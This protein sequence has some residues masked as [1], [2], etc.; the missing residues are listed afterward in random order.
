VGLPSIHDADS[1]GYAAANL[2]RFST[3]WFDAETG[4]GYWGYRYYT[5]EL[6]RW[7]NRDP[8]EEYGGTQLY[9][10]LGN[11]PPGKYDALGG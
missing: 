2:F 3:K 6:G 7:M 11:T 5:P 4:L 8:M 1:S 9:N 10:F